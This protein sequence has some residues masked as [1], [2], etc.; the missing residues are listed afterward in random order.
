M[1]EG[2]ALIG[3]SQQD[4]LC[5]DWLRPT[6]ATAWLPQAGGVGTRGRA[7]ARWGQCGSSKVFM[8][9]QAQIQEFKEFPPHLLCIDQNRDG[10]ITEEDLKDTY[11]QLG[12]ENNRE[13]EEL[14]EMLE[15]GKGPMN[16][17]LFLT[18][19][20]EKLN[21][22]SPEESILN[23][24]RLLSTRTT[25]PSSRRFTRLLLTQAEKF[26]LEEVEQLLAVTPVDISG[27]IDY[28]SL[29]YIVTHRDEKED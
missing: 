25:G 29:C 5:S 15:E 7:V 18:L 26:S 19:F 6:A 17:T 22:T 9:E 20:G 2:C 23:A 14:E 10:I 8:F 3:C 11:V 16:F 28:K 21:G 24:S 27:D 13:R 12:Q 4:S 1:G